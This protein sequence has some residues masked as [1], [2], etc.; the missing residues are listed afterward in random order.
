MLKQVEDLLAFEKG[1]P[2]REDKVGLN[3]KRTLYYALGQPIGDCQQ[4]LFSFRILHM[5]RQL[6]H[7][8]VLPPGAQVKDVRSATNKWV[9]KYRRDGSFQG[10]SSF[11]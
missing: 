5:Q 8:R 10:K 4:A 2:A 1:D 6:R 3:P 7:G 9:A 11:G